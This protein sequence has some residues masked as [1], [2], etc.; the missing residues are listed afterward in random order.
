MAT[1]DL[2]GPASRRA[3]RRECSPADAVTRSLLGYLVL[4]GPLYVASSVVQGLTREG[5]SFA[6]HEWSLL[7]VGR[8]GWIQVATFALTGAMVVAGALG[9]RRFLRA[10]GDAPRR[11][12][13]AARWAWRAVA[14]Y[15]ACLV[16]A[17]VFR[18]DPARGFP[19]GTASGPTT[20]ASWHGTLH[21]VAGSLGFVCLVVA[22]FLVARLRVGTVPGGRRG[23]VVD[24]TVG[25]IV[26]LG[27]AAVATGADSVAVNLAFTCAV[28]VGFAWLAALGVTLYR[29]TGTLTGGGAS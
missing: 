20:Q 3:P 29:H 11:P 13:T 19:P 22:C 6:H 4:A 16:L 15:G 21:L 25:V 12:R 8:L 9:V 27:L 18:A 28:V 14:A 2:T 7:A 1:T 23:A 26:L 17:G 10:S 24:R 5:F